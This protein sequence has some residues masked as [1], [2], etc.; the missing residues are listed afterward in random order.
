MD[1]AWYAGWRHVFKLDPDREISDEALDAICMSGTD[2]IMV[3]G[4]SG[5]TFDNTVELMSRIRR[6]AVDCVLE[7]TSL[8]AAVPGF[9]YYFVPLVLNTDDAQW[10]VGRQAEAMK[11]FGSLIPWD[12][13]A[14]EGYIILNQDATAA[15]VS[16]ART[17][18]EPAEVIALVQLADRLMRMPAVYLEYSGTFGDM[19]LVRRASEA[20][21]QARVIYGGGINNAERAA[22]AAR[23]A[24]TVVVGNIIYSDLQAA[25]STVQAVQDTPFE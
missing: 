9:D 19:S 25:L 8:E 7:V 14:G 12:I 21:S 24:H 22:E 15:Q 23:A 6:Y 17:E 4:S 5:I 3:G 16:G 20:V 10:L 2:A 11:E 18:L 1:G 13:T